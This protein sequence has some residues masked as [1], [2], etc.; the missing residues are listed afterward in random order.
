MH[1]FSDLT[2]KIQADID[3]FGGSLPERNAIAWRGYLTA[4]LEWSA[5]P[6]PV[7]RELADLIPKITDDPVTAIMLGRDN[8]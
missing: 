4:L 5:M 3:R 2:S 8:M 6:V 7:Y 1:T